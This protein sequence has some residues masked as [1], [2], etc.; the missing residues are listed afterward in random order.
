MTA[1]R[2]VTSRPRHT[3]LDAAEPTVAVRRASCRT[4]GGPLAILGAERCPACAPA[5]LKPRGWSRAPSKKTIDRACADMEWWF[6]IRESELGISASGFEPAQSGGDPDV[7]GATIVRAM[8]WR[9]M[10]ALTRETI[11][12]PRI[13]AMSPEMR[14]DARA[15]YVPPAVPLLARDYFH[16]DRGI[17]GVV[18]MCGLAMR[19]TAFASAWIAAGEARESAKAVAAREERERVAY[20]EA[21]RV[22]RAKALPMPLPPSTRPRLTMLEWFTAEFQ[23]PDAQR[24]R[25][26]DRARDEAK[27]MRDRLLEQYLGYE[28]PAVKGEVK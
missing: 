20:V 3:G 9:R 16:L 26:C 24:P 18:T 22:A 7:C 25:W 13:R 6:A 14:D 11:V 23:R 1:A 8:D 2:T 28:A 17:E 5:D 19:T 21:C 12:G 4:C 10:R 15:L 27:A